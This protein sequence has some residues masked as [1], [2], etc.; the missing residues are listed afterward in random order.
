MVLNY[1]KTMYLSH[2]CL[3]VFLCVYNLGLLFTTASKETQMCTNTERF[4][5]KHLY[6]NALIQPVTAY[7]S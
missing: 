6:I 1:S 3:F 2:V 4:A 7:R 5:I